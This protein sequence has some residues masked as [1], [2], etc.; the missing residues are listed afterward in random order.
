MGTIKY[1]LN[2]WFQRKRKLIESLYKIN[3]KLKKRVFN[4]GGM[5]SQKQYMKKTKEQ[6]TSKTDYEKNI[7]PPN[8]IEVQHTKDDF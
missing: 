3:T 8:G 2:L 6:H 7:S 1:K 4:L 5:S